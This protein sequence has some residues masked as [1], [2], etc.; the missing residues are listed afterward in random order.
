MTYNFSTERTT[1]KYLLLNSCGIQKFYDTD[2]FCLRENG[3]IDYHILYI[4]EGVCHLVIDDIETVV[5]S[6]NI[7][8]FYPG[9]KQQ[10]SFLKCDKSVSYFIHFTGVGC[11]DLL[12][13][14]NPNK[15]HVIYIGKSIDFKETFEK[16]MREHSFKQPAYEIY[17]S[18]LLAELFS[19]ISRSIWLNENNIGTRNEKII[20]NACQTIYNNLST[21]TISG[22]ASQE[23]LSVGR[24]SHIFK[25]VMGMS[26]LEY[27]NS[28]K[29]QKAKDLITYTDI[30]INKI[31]KDI[32]IED[33]N[34]FSRLFKKYAKISPSEY[35]KTSF[36]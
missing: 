35:R 1:E 12:K 24:F 36:K 31:A 26:P 10:Y 20:Q 8:I 7:I 22:L 11:E 3:R 18:S 19:I 34:Y 28:M 29:I 4:V 13:E 30:P 16:M 25:E 15:K 21:V 32:G 33:Q 17:C 2:G 9:E 27:I 14:I 5:P 6:G 23:F